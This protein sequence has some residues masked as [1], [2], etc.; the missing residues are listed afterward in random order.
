MLVMGSESTTVLMD[1]D[2]TVQVLGR[3]YSMS[4][5]EEIQDRLQTAAEQLDAD[6][7]AATNGRDLNSAELVE[8]VIA[9]ALEYLCE[10]SQTEPFDSSE[11]QDRLIELTSR[12]ETVRPQPES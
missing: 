12:L 8:Q 6:L 3:S 11:V 5:S 9:L 1:T 10:G 4:C 2:V 7:Q